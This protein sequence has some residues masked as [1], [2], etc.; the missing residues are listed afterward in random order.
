MLSVALRAF[1]LTMEFFSFY[2]AVSGGIMDYYD[3]LGYASYAD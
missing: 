1:D 3:C 2:E